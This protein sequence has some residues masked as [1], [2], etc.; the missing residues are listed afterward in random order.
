MRISFVKILLII[1]FAVAVALLC[2]YL[3]PEGIPLFNENKNETSGIDEQLSAPPPPAT[4]KADTGNKDSLKHDYNKMAVEKNRVAIDENILPAYEYKN[5]SDLTGGNNTDMPEAG[6][7]NDGVNLSN[8][9]KDVFNQPRLISL[10]QAYE[11]YRDKVIFVDGRDSDQFEEGHI[12]GAV[13]LPYMHF[14]Q[15]AGRLARVDKNDPIVTYCEGAECDISIR[16]GNE[17]FS[18]GYR[19]VFVFFGG[20]EEWRKADYPVVTSNPDLQLN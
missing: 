6:S 9:T 8:L 4:D 19:K 14:E 1:F 16:L 15:F 11:L 13:N 7:S 12:A 20:W 3:Q 10:A 5:D 17:L 2:N 18:K